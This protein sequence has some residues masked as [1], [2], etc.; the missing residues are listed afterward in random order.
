[1]TAFNPGDRVRLTAL[2][3]AS[4]SIESTVDANGQFVGWAAWNH[5]QAD[6]EVIEPADDPS[7]DLVG[8]VRRGFTHTYTKIRPDH[9]VSFRDSNAKPLQH[10]DDDMKGASETIGAVPGTPAAEV[11]K[12]TTV[13]VFKDSDGDYWYER[14]PNSFTIH[15]GYMGGTWSTEWTNYSLAKLRR[16]SAITEVEPRELPA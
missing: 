13:R 3:P 2:P 9:W 4:G 6:V 7:K 1:M 15:W 16:L 11:Q 14:E 10:F 8:T 5:A 12:P